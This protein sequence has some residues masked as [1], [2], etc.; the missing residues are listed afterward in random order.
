MIYSGSFW[1]P[2]K[3]FIHLVHIPNRIYILYA[4]VALTQDLNSTRSFQTS[5]TMF[6]CPSSIIH[7]ESWYHRST[8]ARLNLR[9]LMGTVYMSITLLSVPNICCVAVE[10]H[11]EDIDKSSIDMFERFLIL[12]FYGILE[13]SSPFSSSLGRPEKYGYNPRRRP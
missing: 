2:S 7:A 8:I 5:F 3:M 11:L 1:T 13:G 12:V 9:S 4:L 10:G 6:V